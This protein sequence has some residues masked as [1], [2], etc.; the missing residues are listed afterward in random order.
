MMVIIRVIA[1]VKEQAEHEFEHKL[2]MVVEEAKKV[3]G[4]LTYEWY[5]H[6]DISCQ[7]SIYGLFESKELFDQYKVS[8]VVEMIGKELLPLTLS[9]PEYQHFHA[10]VFEQG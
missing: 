6:P 1:Q 4:Y 2:R 5:K 9:K 10:E 8:T 7:F 3:E